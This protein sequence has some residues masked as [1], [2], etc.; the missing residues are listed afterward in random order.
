MGRTIWRWTK[1]VLAGLALLLVALVIAGATYQA[2]ATANDQAA[3]PPP[4]RM[5]D[6]G[7]FKLHILCAG[8][9]VTGRPTVILESGLATST[10]VWV[11][12]QTEVARSVRVCAYDRAGIG[13][14]EPSPNPRDARHIAGE[15]H[16]LLKNAGIAPPYVLAGHSSGG[17]Y[18]RAYQRLYPADVVGMAL[19][20]PTPEAFAYSSEMSR[21]DYTSIRRV[22]SV[23]PVLATLGVIRLLPACR[24]GLPD[25]FPALQRAQYTALC[26]ASRPWPAQRDEHIHLPEPLPPVVVLTIPLGVFT[27]GKNIVRNPLWGKLH[28]KIAA[29]SPNSLHRVF[30]NAEHSSFLVEKPYAHESALLIE[31]VVTA[32]QTNAPLR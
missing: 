3:Y 23:T 9:A 10:P 16:T 21:N 27:A 2:I 8:T 20:E 31:K 4:G 17:I 12:V 14:S 1:R 5:V 15:L 26:A 6:V 11:R 28:D 22:L 7:G 13:W 25:D 18:A 24:Q 19:L 32:A 30:P 29:L